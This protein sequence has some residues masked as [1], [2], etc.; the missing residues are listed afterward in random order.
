MNKMPILILLFV[1]LSAN[2]A[3][4]EIAPV[5]LKKLY[6]APSAASKLVFDIPVD[7]TLLDMSEDLNW[8]KVKIAFN[9][10][11]LQYKYTG[12]TKIP[13]GDEIITRLAKQDQ[14]ASD[15]LNEK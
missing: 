10:G 14:V 15:D 2:I 8:Y 5:S 9:I 6:A 1:I 3:L 7:V 11:P 4:G 13:V 12:W